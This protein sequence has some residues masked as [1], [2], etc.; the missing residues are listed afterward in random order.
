VSI[1]D[2]IK[3]V[4]DVEA[5]AVQTIRDWFPVYVRELE[6]QHSVQQDAYPLPHSYIT[7]E[8]FDREDADQ[9]P[10]VVIVSPGL[11]RPPRQEGDGTFRCFFSIAA[12]VFVAGKDRASTKNLVRVYTAVLRSILLQKQALGGIADGTTWLDESYDD[13]FRFSDTQ[14]VG[15]GQVVFEIEVAGV[16]NRYGGPAVYGS[17]PPAPDPGTQPGSDWGE[18][19][20]VTADVELMEG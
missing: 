7:A 15:A 5:A 8:R 12:G 4:T 17:P 20:T 19:E 18:V 11:N 10:A 1:F 2:S 3:L 6:L 16:V 9:L 14:T 13:N